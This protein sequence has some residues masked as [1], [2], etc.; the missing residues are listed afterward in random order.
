MEEMRWLIWNNKRLYS[1]SPIVRLRGAVC[2]VI[3]TK[4]PTC[5]E[6]N[7]NCGGSLRP[8]GIHQLHRAGRDG[9]CLCL[10]QVVCQRERTSDSRE[11]PQADK[12]SGSWGKCKS[13]RGAGI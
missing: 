9:L 8:T 5:R 11:R 6:L 10:A 2:N 7:S 13:T 4:F 3:N 12:D 1:I